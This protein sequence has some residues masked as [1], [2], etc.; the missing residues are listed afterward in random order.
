MD[1]TRVQRRILASWIEHKRR[2]GKQQVNL[3]HT[4]VDAL[5]QLLGE[6]I[7][8]EGVDKQG[9]LEHWMHK[10]GYWK[11][12]MKEWWKKVHPSA[13]DTQWQTFGPDTLAVD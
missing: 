4:Y 8:D 2:V 12:A 9:K 7:D 10:K 6:R 11:L 5:Q 1:E 3:R 13:Q